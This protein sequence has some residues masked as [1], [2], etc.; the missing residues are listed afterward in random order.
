[1][2][3]SCLKSRKA[4]RTIRGRLLLRSYEHRGSDILSTIREETIGPRGMKI[5]RMLFEKFANA[6]REDETVVEAVEAVGPGH[7]PRQSR[8]WTSRRN[9]MAKLRNAAA[10]E[11]YPKVFRLSSCWKRISS[12]YSGHRAFRSK[13]LATR[14]IRQQAEIARY[15][16][17]AYRVLIH[18]HQ[19][20]RF[21]EPV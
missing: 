11:P 15:D 6:V 1:M 8:S 18:A 16:Y 14:S 20:L 7:R 4:Q 17:R 19:G 3:S 2:C 5:D 12:S 21:P 13:R 10:V 9:L